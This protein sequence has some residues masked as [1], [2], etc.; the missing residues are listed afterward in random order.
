MVIHRLV[1]VAKGASCLWMEIFKDGVPSIK[2]S[3]Y[4]VE[5]PQRVLIE[6]KCARWTSRGKSGGKGGGVG[7]VDG[8]FE[9]S[10]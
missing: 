7:E 1:F 3:K 2:W 8:G 4:F 10:F 5:G 6:A 9:V